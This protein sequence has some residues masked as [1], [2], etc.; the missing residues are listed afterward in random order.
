[1][2]IRILSLL[3][4]MSTPIVLPAEESSKTIRVGL[5]SN[6]PFVVTEGGKFSG[7]AVE[8]WE[9]AAKLNGWDYKYQAAG[10]RPLKSGRWA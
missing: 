7:L 1:M 5:V 6:A 2:I 9:E 4:M 10:Q 3:I 8:L